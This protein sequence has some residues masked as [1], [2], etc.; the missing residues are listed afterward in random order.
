MQLSLDF[1]EAVRGLAVATAQRVIIPVRRVLDSLGHQ[2]ETPLDDIDLS[3]KLAEI[4]EG[5]YG[6]TSG[7]QDHIARMMAEQ[8]RHGFKLTDNQLA[9]AIRLSLIHI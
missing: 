7:T 2:W 6:G 4:G 9:Q 5:N 8:M 1:M 3:E